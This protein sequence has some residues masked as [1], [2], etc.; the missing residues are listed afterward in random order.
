MSAW[1]GKAELAV[2]S[3]DFGKLTRRGHRPNWSVD[4]IARPATS[5]IFSKTMLKWFGLQI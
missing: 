4:G 1:W 3:A 2:G 5:F